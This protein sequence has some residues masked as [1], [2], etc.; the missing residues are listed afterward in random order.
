MTTEQAA[1]QPHGPGRFLR[2]IAAFKFIEALTMLG[3]GL[4]T[5]RL[6]QPEVVPLLQDWVDTLPLGTTEQLFAQRA[7]GWIT[8]LAPGKIRALGIGAFIFA[9]VFLAEGIGL[10]MRKLWGEWLTV[11]ATSLLIPVE[12][13]ELCTHATPAKVL[14][15]IVNV[16]VVLYLIWQIRTKPHVH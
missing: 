14:V 11:V 12:I 5:L 7:L 6:L 3:T 13:R 16:A 1:S 4:A 8:G 10:W 9:A 2:W 15:L